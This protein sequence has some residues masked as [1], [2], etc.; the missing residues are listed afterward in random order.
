MSSRKKS[1]ISS[2]I[3]LT[4][5]NIDF[6]DSLSQKS[7]S[8]NGIKLSKSSIAR[9]LLSISKDLEIDVSNVKNPEEL[10][11]RIIEAFCKY[12]G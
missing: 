8:S 12:N 11:D 3:T 10:K 6:L 4:K 2:S 9:A 5:K 7:K 1:T